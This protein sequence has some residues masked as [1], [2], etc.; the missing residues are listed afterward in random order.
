MKAP[1]ELLAIKKPHTSIIRHFVIGEISDRLPSGHWRGSLALMVRARSVLP[2][3]SG[4]VKTYHKAANSASWETAMTKLLLAVS[5]ALAAVILG[6]C[7]IVKAAGECA[8]TERC[9]R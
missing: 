4:L 3:Q 8:R 6:G 5:I 2:A 1:A 7:E 9:F